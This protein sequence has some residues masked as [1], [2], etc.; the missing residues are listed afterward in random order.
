MEYDNSIKKQFLSNPY[1]EEG[2]K[3]QWENYY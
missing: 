2:G 3:K 1:K